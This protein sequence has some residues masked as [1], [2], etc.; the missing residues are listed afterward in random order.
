MPKA[1]MISPSVS[2]SAV[3]RKAPTIGPN[4]VPMPPMMGPRI[5]SMERE[6]WKTCSGNRLL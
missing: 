1:R 4:S 6:M 2:A 3:S 5:S